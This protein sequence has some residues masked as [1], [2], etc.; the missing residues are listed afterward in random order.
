MSEMKPIDPG[1]IIIR[2]CK[3]IRSTQNCP[4][5]VNVKNIASFKY[6]VHLDTRGNIEENLIQV[7]L[8]VNIASV[9]PEYTGEATASFE[10]LFIYHYEGLADHAK[11]HESG[12]VAWGTNLSGA[13]ASITYS[14]SRGLLIAALQSTPL[15][16]FILPVADADELI[17]I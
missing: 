1:K 2:E 8:S 4:G 17:E 7:E 16:D 14:T 11:Q 5:E 12:L 6:D 9:G 10:I 3:I 15:R 13:I